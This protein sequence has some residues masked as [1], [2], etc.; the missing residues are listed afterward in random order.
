MKVRFEHELD[1]RTLF[2]WKLDKEDRRGEPIKITAGVSNRKHG[3]TS[4]LSYFVREPHFLFVRKSVNHAISKLSLEQRE[5][6][7]PQR[8]AIM[9]GLH[10]AGHRVFECDIPKHDQDRMLW[11]SPSKHKHLAVW[12]EVIVI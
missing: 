8:D 11:R 6:F 5:H 4:D 2:C 1:G 10:Y 7:R 12:V 3:A 9:E